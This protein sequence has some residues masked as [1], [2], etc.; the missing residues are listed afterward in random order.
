M[1]HFYSLLFALEEKHHPTIEDALNG[2]PLAMRAVLDIVEEGGIT[3]NPFQVGKAYYIETLTLYYIGIVE[4]AHPTY[5]K[6]RQVSWI[7]WTGRKSVTF[8]HKKFDKKLYNS[9]E[10]KPRTE[11]MGDF[12][13]SLGGINGWEEWPIENVPTESIQ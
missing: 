12:N 7:H 2:D 8:K 13:L 10:T 11:Y 4:E 9:N 3:M 6:M 5:I 1:L